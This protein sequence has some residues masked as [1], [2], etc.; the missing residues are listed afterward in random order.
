M[1][2]IKTNLIKRTTWKVFEKYKD[3]VQP[4]FVEN[5]ALVMEA[6]KGPN[7]KM[8][9]IIAGYLARIAKKQTE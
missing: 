9:N 1:G 8:R 6:L 4:T 7:K 2:R 5:K 3:R